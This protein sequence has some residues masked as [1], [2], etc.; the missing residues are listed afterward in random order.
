MN[1]DYSLIDANLARV[2]EGLRVLEDIVRF[3]FADKELF[4]ALKILRHSLAQT[5]LWF[6]TG[7]VLKSRTGIDVGTGQVNSAEYHRSS[8][9]GIIRA[10]S[11]R[12]TE[13]L[14]TLEEFA[15]LYTNSNAVFI[16]KAR[17]QV[18]ALERDLLIRTPHYYLN[19]YFEEGIVY[20]IS[21]SIDDMKDFIEAGARVVQLRDKKSSKDLVAQKAKEICRFLHKRYTTGK[22]KVIFLMSDYADVAASLPVDG[23]HALALA[24]ELV[25]ARKILGSNKI[26]G[27]SVQSVAQAAQAEQNGA[28]YILVG[29]LYVNPTQ[30]ER[31]AV[32][33]DTLQKIS[34]QSMIPV[35]ATGGVTKETLREVYE[36]GGKNVAVTAAAKEFFG[37]K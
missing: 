31:S 20:P 7:L 9:Y 35:V 4:E 6:G 33:L 27:Q 28:D 5:E 24:G 13:A 8:L 23:M 11:N 29:S 26:I 3:V 22:E 12:V 25:K 21:D 15:K 30:S 19:Q 32:G 36:H 2:K 10:N 34:E 1:K 17:Y 37:K 18:Y 14:R 16:E